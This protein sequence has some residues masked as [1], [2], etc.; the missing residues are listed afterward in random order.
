[1]PFRCISATSRSITSTSKGAGSGRTSRGSI[2]S[3][4]STQSVHAID[5]VRE[6]PNLVLRRRKLSFG[7]AGDLDA[8]IRSVA[9][10][11]TAALD[12]RRF[13]RKEPPAGKAQPLSQ[14]RAARDAGADQPM[15]RRRLVRASRAVR[16][17]LR[18]P[19]LPA[20]R[21]PE[22]GGVAGDPWSRR[23]TDF[24]TF[25]RGRAVCPECRRNSPSMRGKWP[26]CG[27]GGCSRAGSSSWRAAKCCISRPNR[28]K[29]TSTASAGRFPSGI[30]DAEADVRFEGVHA[31]LDDFRRP[32]FGLEAWQ[33]FA[34]RGLNRVSLGVESGD[35]EVRA[36]YGKGW[37]DDGTASDCR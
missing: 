19:A 25:T 22:R 3:R 23:W 37:E 1:M 6:G 7:E 2:I 20:A 26:G 35:L 14:R 10:D 21:V 12:A 8:R 32:R 11:L 9:L 15:G 29:P 18:P 30:R 17:H 13:L 31:F 27:D 24:R 33:R 4:A 34:E 16:R 36:I 28:L 5:R